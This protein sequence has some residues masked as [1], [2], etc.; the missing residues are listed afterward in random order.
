MNSPLC[1]PDSVPTAVAGLAS[2]QT[3]RQFNHRVMGNPGGWR[4]QPSRPR[5]TGLLFVV[6]AP[7]SRLFLIDESHPG[8]AR[9]LASLTNGVL[10]HLAFA[11][12]FERHALHFR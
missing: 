2:R 1:G 3:A 4:K 6:R 12:L 9:S 11:E 10:H 8:R 7:P 5:A